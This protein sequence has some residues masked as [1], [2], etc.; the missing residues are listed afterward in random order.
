MKT[1]TPI[2]FDQ[3]EISQTYLDK[4]SDLVIVEEPFQIETIANEISRRDL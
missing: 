1:D 4:S 2:S 3:F